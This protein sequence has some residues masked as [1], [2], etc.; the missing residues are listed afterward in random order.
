[1]KDWSDVHTKEELRKRYASYIPALQAIA[2]RYGYA[3]AVHGSMSRD[4]DLVAVPWVPK[5]VAPETLVMAL[6][7]SMT[8]YSYTR[9]H[10]KKDS[11]HGKKPHGRKAYTLLIANLA[12]DFEGMSLGCPQRHAWIDLSVVSRIP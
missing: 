10:W 11:R 7:E 9:A 4:L 3:L 8:G 5:A 2:M 12:Y 1:M 6:H